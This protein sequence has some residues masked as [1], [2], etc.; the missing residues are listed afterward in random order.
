[1]TAAAM[2]AWPPL[3]RGFGVAK[4][5]QWAPPTGLDAT[6]EFA[7]HRLRNGFTC[8]CVSKPLNSWLFV[9]RGNTIK[10]K[11]K[12]WLTMPGG[13]RDGS[14]FFFFFYKHQASDTTSPRPGEHTGGAI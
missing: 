10:P 6:R 4:P 13:R 9:S 5:S 14:T 11:N 7:W 2:S 3:D 8:L 1:M 12:S